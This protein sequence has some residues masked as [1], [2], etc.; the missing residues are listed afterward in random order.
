M[1]ELLGHWLVGVHLGKV[2]DLPTGLLWDKTEVDAVLGTVQRCTDES[3]LYLIC[4]LSTPVCLL[5]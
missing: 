3:F 1:P 4:P 5:L 2:P